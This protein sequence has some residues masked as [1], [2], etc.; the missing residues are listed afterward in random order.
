MLAA[1]SDGQKR[2]LI[3]A[4]AIGAGFLITRLLNHPAGPDIFLLGLLPALSTGLAAVALILI[5]RT[6]RVINFA[7]IAMGLI[8]GQVFYE[9]ISQSLLPYPF[10][11]AVAVLGGPL[12][13]ALIGTIF[14][15]L[16]YRHPRLVLTVGTILV[17]GLVAY[18]SG[19]L[20]GVFHQEGEVRTF[21]AILGPYPDTSVT[22]G[23]TPFRLIH[24][25]HFLLLAGTA[26]GL[27]IFFRRTRVGTAIRASAENA[28][29]A[30]LLGINVKALQVGVWTIAGLVSGVGVIAVQPVEGFN[31][32]VAGDFLL[33]VLPL[34]ACVVARM[35][36]MPVAFFAGTGLVL[37]RQSM[38]F[39][40]NDP[41]FLD[42]GL[43]GV[44]LIGLLVQRGKILTRADESTSWKAVREVRMT[45]REMLAL[46]VIN[47]T[48]RALILV[49]AIFVLLF[50]F[51]VSAQTTANYT[52]VWTTAI[53]ATSLVI[54]TGWTGQISLG[55][56]FF[57][58][59]G[60]FAG[61]VMTSRMGIPYWFAVPG[62][63][64]VGAVAAFLVGLPALRIKGL[65]LAV[66][67]FA[68]AAVGAVLLFD[69]RFLGNWV[70]R[71]V[72]PP[73]LLFLDFE[74]HKSMYY[75]ML[76]FF[77]VTAV[78][79]GALRRSRA[80][81]ILIGIRDNETGIQ[82]FGIDI[83]RARLTAFAI[84]GFIAA[85]GGALL[86]HKDLGMSEQSYGAFASLLIF[87]LAVIGGIS[88]VS[89]VFLG[90][91]L[92]TGASQ[93]LGPQGQQLLQSVLGI[94]MLIFIPGGLA[95]IVYGFRDAILRVI[96]MRQ[97]IVVPS[98]FS[99]YSP[100]AWEKQLTPLAPT[101]QSQG[102]AAL[103]PDQRY[104]L[105][106]KVFGEA[107]AS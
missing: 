51:F 47:R 12:I 75:L 45:P 92:F 79:V 31:P 3:G 76:A 59:L 98:L 74:D 56:W 63:G 77:L 43:V 36:S 52:T 69:P 11:L 33:L 6:V 19:Q 9:L 82:S 105:P 22:I 91:L 38:S 10:A 49:G 65:F 90:A 34:A 48:R 23:V 42:I 18:I 25:I 80:G 8:A 2:I 16:F 86:V 30:S 70:P 37:L 32:A 97:H 27:V 67:T 72:D 61:G 99:D 20:D 71:E 4:G 7:Q 41:T 24:L 54:L 96:A 103:R 85:M 60:A 83:V 17:V 15:T 46:P 28:D 81:R 50:P 102:I 95:Q 21:P 57:A 84:S 53:I 93:V 106:T 39:S 87:I 44:I 40:L 89:G 58:G 101:V 88:S 29:R 73:T 55:Q 107:P 1:L 5:Y 100:E 14:A 66:S 26:V 68:L 104:A 62:A 35:Q 64:L 13:G 78:V 94:G